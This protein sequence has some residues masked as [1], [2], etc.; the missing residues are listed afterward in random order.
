MENKTE[1]ALRKALLEDGEM[2]YDLYEFEMEYFLD[3]WQGEMDFDK[4]DFVFVFDENEG[5]VAM[6]A[7]SKDD[8]LYVNGEARDKL[9]S[10]WNENY[11]KN[12]DEFM[13]FFLERLSIGIFPLIGVN[14]VNSEGED[15][16]KQGKSKK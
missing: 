9:K 15:D 10:L 3:D 11:T 2:S 14:Y 16:E 7:I 5:D 6:V 8:E 12:I 1:T 13:P 4:D